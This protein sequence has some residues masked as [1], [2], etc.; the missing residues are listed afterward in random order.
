L[1]GSG[2]GVNQ[3]AEPGNLTAG[4]RLVNYPF[5][6]SLVDK[7]NGADKGRAGSFPVA[8]S[9]GLA[10]LLDLGPH[11]GPDVG[12]AGIANF[13]LTISLDGRFVIGQGFI[14]HR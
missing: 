5:A 10:N 11:G 8:S 12:V 7:G 2:E 14:L 4:G 6:G 1:T 3:F 13:V 9:D